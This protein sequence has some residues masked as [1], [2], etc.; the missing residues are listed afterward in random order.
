MPTRRPV[1]STSKKKAIY[2]LL[3]NPGL[4]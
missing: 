4:K 3:N 2:T 1:I